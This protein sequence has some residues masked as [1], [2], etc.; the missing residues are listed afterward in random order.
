[1]RG[2]H[3]NNLRK[4]SVKVTEEEIEEIKNLDWEGYFR[5]YPNENG[6]IRTCPACKVMIFPQEGETEFE[7]KCCGAKITL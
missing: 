5:D 7:C 3:M 1:M 4:V 6:Y 2:D